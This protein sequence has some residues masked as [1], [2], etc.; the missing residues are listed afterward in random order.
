ML[1]YPAA[2]PLTQAAEG[3]ESLLISP[4]GMLDGFQGWSSLWSISSSTSG[5]LWPE[6]RHILEMLL[7]FSTLSSA[8]S[9]AQDAWQTSVPE[10]FFH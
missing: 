1:V 6:K 8:G 5:F 7:H 4:L 2:E 9:R 3:N 10:G